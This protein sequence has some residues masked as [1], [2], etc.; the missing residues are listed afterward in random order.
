MHLHRMRTV[1]CLWKDSMAAK[2][3]I[4]FGD[5]KEKKHVYLRTTKS[6]M[7]LNSCVEFC[8]ADKLLF[9]WPVSQ[10]WAFSLF[11]DV[12]FSKTSF[13]IPSGFRWSPMSLVLLKGL[14]LGALWNGPPQF[15]GRLYA[16][17]PGSALPTVLINSLNHVSFV[18]GRKQGEVV[19]T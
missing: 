6:S 8:C 17:V 12:D 19:N 2:N 13:M 5:V 10:S 3:R 15:G 4:L 16:I 1:P 14:V 9:I 7:F 11:I 18:D